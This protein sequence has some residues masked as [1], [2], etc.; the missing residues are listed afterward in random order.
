MLFYTCA[1]SL[2]RHVASMR[3]VLALVP[4]TYVIESLSVVFASSSVKDK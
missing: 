3:L 1:D 2:S 4:D